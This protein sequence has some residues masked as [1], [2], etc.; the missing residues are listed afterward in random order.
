KSKGQKR[1]NQVT[2]IIDDVETCSKNAKV[3]VSH[4][5]STSNVLL[6]AINIRVLIYK[7]LIAPK[8]SK[9]CHDNALNKPC[10]KR[11]S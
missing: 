10:S 2:G 1:R 5:Q 7:S 9:I 11:K 4:V 8:K 6:V 3:S